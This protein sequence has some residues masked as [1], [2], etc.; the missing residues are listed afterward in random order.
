MTQQAKQWLIGG[1]AVAVLLASSG[2]IY[3]TQTQTTKYNVELH[4]RVGE[5]MAEETA[6]LVGAKGRVVTIA[7]NTKDWPELR[8]QLDSFKA[9]LNQ[10]GQYELRNY[11]LDGKDQPKYGV[12]TG[13]SGRRYVRTV[14]KNQ[15][16]D[17]FVSFIGAPSISED[18][19]SELHHKPRLVAETRSP[20][21]LP[22][23]F[24]SELLQA[25]IVSRFEF[26]SPGPEKPSNPTEWFVKRY[27][28]I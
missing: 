18:E 6:R 28:V 14:K 20:D 24:G 19:L 15:T 3:R 16:A 25:A 5:V 7:I 10:L 13:L 9:R 1:A 4:Q 2:W 17:V 11:E 22:K 27:Q 23:L 26:P 12:G 21:N 8:V